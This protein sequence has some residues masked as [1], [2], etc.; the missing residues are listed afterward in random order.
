M[1]AGFSLL[2]VTISVMLAA[3]IATVL[4]ASFFQTQKTVKRSNVAID[5]HTA[6]I[7]CY[8]QFEKD[9]SSAFIPY[10]AASLI[11]EDKKKETEPAKRRGEEDKQIQEAKEPIEHIFYTEKGESNV[12]LLTWLTTNTLPG[13]GNTTPRAIR[14][15]YKLKPIHGQQQLFALTR[16]EST[17]YSLKSFEA[18]SSAPRAYDILTNIE[19]LTFK[20]W[21]EEASEQEVANK[22]NKESKQV[23]KTDQKKE[24]VKLTSW[25][26]QDQLKK[27]KKYLPAFLELNGKVREDNSQRTYEFTWIFK[28]YCYDYQSVKPVKSEKEKPEMQTS[29]PGEDSNKLKAD[30]AKAGAELKSFTNMAGL[31]P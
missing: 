25:G 19:N 20:V 29:K 30:Q 14:V 10:G 2:E 31:R 11:E 3:I 27:F 9:I 17:N 18:L 21:I 5:I 15:V 24:Y 16:Q 4:Y 1:K 26:A 12:T 8:N 6:L 22:E 13:Y 7:A 23:K 28:L